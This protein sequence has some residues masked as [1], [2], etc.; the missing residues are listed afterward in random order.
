MQSS[1]SM[2]VAHDSACARARSHPSKPARVIVPASSGANDIGFEL[3][4]PE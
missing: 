1:M 4:S 3:R 2:P